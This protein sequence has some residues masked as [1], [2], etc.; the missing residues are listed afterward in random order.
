M[1]KRILV[2][3]IIVVLA[4]AVGNV[5]ATDWLQFGYDQAHSGFN[6]AETGYSTAGGNTVLFNY[7]LPSSADSSPVYLGNVTTASG[8]KNLLFIVTKNGTLLAIDADAK[9]KTNSVVWSH[10][11][12]GAGSLTTGS[13]AIDPNLQYVY[14]YGNDGNVHKYQVGDGT[15]ILKDP[16][17]PTV[18][19]TTD[20]PELSSS[21]PDIEK[22]AAGLSIATVGGVDYLYSVTDGYIGDGG[23]YQG[24]VTT[25]NLSTKTQVVFNTLCSDKGNTHFDETGD[26]SVTDCPNHQSGIWGRPGTIFDA[27][28]GKI[29]MATGNFGASID[30]KN[31]GESVIALPAN[32]SAAR[33]TP[34]DSYTPSEWA[35]MGDLDL[36]SSS[37]ALLPEILASTN[38]PH[39]A[40]QV[41]KDSQVRLLDI[42]HLNNGA[43]VG[44][45]GEL[46][47]QPLPQGDSVRSQPAVWVNPTDG[48][49]WVYIANDS[50]IVA[51]KLTVTSGVPALT[52]QWPTSGSGDA[53]TS[54]VVANGTVY[55]MSGG[56]IRA[57]DAV[58][59]HAV[60]TSGPWTTNSNGGTHWQSL[61]VVN[62]R[63]YAIDDGNPS[64]LWGY[65]LDG[66][67]RSSFDAPSG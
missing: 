19:L 67:F 39:M 3:S 49:A 27:R 8:I 44:H 53:G 14:A 54:P 29:F 9:T 11:P 12:S 10:R 25:I 64:Q 28:S 22:G 17:H 47:K 2:G 34:S 61:I 35:S 60:V 51:Y 13:P 23:D 59:G 46:Q 57:L 31:W 4:C 36:G 48:S 66:V 38:H 55:Y 5:N 21:K 1:R 45:G 33:A 42:D 15:Q 6:R 52:K 32:M 58:S 41:G 24:H 62:G 26:S 20:W 56:L 50:G 65:Q 43:G 30:G 63:V 40:V 18:G 37:P 16:A 7:D